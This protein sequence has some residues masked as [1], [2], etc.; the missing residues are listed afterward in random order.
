[1]DFAELQTCLKLLPDIKLEKPGTVKS[2]IP[3]VPGH[4]R[5]GPP[6]PAADE[7]AQ[8]RA[9]APSIRHAEVVRPSVFVTAR[10]PP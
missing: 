4:L 8:Y 3:G 1:M 10:A 6:V 5:H 7:I 9:T 2:H